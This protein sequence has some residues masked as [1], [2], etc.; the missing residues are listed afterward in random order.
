LVIDEAHVIFKDKKAQDLLDSM[1]REIRS[2]GVSVILLSQGISEF[3]QPGTEFSSNCDNAFLLDINDKG[4]S[5]AIS[6]FLGLSDRE[7]IKAARSIEKIKT[8]M[9]I[10]NIGEFEKGSLFTLNQIH[11]DEI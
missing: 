4:N 9:A 1:L 3:T 6:K 7:G 5:K 10:S 8:G 2:K 11:K